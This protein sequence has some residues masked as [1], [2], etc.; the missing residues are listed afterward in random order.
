[1]GQRIQQPQQADT[2]PDWSKH[3]EHL[4]RRK[5]SSLPPIAVKGQGVWI[6]DSDGNRYLDAAGGC[7]V[8][9][10][11]HG[12][13]EIAQALAHQAQTLTYVN[14]TQFTHPAA[15]ALASALAPHLETTLP[16]PQCYFMC[17]GT[18]AVEAA[19]KLARQLWVVRGQT[20]KTLFISRTP[21]YHGSSLTCL[22][23]SAREHYKIPFGPYLQQDW[24]KIPAPQGDGQDI[25]RAKAL[26]TLLKEI[27]PETVAAFIAEPISGSSTGAVVPDDG[28][29]D[30]VQDICKQYDILLIADEVMCGMGRTGKWLASEHFGLKPDIVTLGKGLNSGYAPL[31]AMVS[32]G[33][34]LEELKRSGANFLHAGT[35]THTPLICATGLAVVQHLEKHQLVE[36]AAKKGEKLHWALKE[37]IQP[38]P[39]VGKIRGKGLFA[40]IEIMANPDSRTPF[41]RAMQ[42]VE[43]LVLIAASNH[44]L[45]LWPNVGHI[46]GQDGDL[47]ILAP[48]FSITDEELHLLIEKLALSLKGFSQWATQTKTGAEIQ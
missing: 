42:A 8:V 41:P 18:E 36:R 29:W 28:Y 38:L 33:A 15:E 20:G 37:S 6:E 32:K 21:S 45:I 44:G 19:I 22:S 43:K 13:P 26:E 25:G 35:Y 34:L 11:G 10:I 39:Y 48:P 40:G 4:F 2:P 14:G 17:T 23:L 16:N 47:I 3:S 9:N 31:S 5:L 46:N 7:A 27:G 30:T 12:V 1:M 24:L